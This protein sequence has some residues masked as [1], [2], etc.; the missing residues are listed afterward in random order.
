MNEV[1]LP[2]LLQPIQPEPGLPGPTPSSPRV[3]PMRRPASP[4]GVLL[5]AVLVA[6]VGLG[7]CGG[8]GASPAPGSPTPGGSPASPT[9]GG[10]IAH[11][12]GPTDLILREEVG[13]GFVPIWFFATQA[14]FFSLY[15][16]G[17]V[18]YRDE[19]AP[20]PEPGPDG[21]VRGHP[22][23]IAKLS[24]EQVQELLRFALTEG[25]LA[26]ARPHYDAPGV[27][28][29]PTTVFVIRAAG[30]DKTVSVY[31]LGLGASAPGDA[32]AR[33]AFV[34][35]DER[36]R[37]LI[38]SGSLGGPT[39]KPDRWRG[40]LTEAGAGAGEARAW[41]WPAIAPAEFVADPSG[42]FPM[43]RRTMSTAEVDAL[44]LEGIEGGFH[45]LLLEGPDGKIYTFGLRPLLPDEA[46]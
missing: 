21:L 32:P 39:W 25:G 17:T 42:E 12:T 13:G 6:S 45:G 46:A 36:L 41:P 40:T 26:A 37:S 27:A 20:L 33:A 31:A 9:G 5:A 34:R 38:S 16:D 23:R 35:L 7:A 29:A 15:G 24:E 4:L 22:F 44:G 10:A 18:I 14:P 30:L 3:R 28:D 11:P 2:M 43:P 1:D 19:T 8:P